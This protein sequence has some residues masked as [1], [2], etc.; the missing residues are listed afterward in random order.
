[1]SNHV[2]FLEQITKTFGQ[3]S[4]RLQ[5]LKGIDLQVSRGECL[6]IVGPSGAGKS[7]LMHIA[8]GLMSPTTG[9]VELQGKALPELCD[10]ELSQVRNRYGGFIV[11]L[12][13]RRREFSAGENVALP[14]LMGGETLGEVRPR[15]H[16]L[17]ERVGLS[18]RAQHRPG[19]LS[20][21]EQQRVAIARAL[22][23]RPA[24]LLA[25]EPTGDL[26]AVT[27]EGIHDLLLSLTRE[28]GQTLVLVTHN[29]ELS[30]LADRIITLRDGKI[31]V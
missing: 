29:P 10:L 22:I 9:R 19:E 26:D 23:N 18:E 11:Q 5:V 4:K 14:A 1:M 27:A 21:G 12:H 3:N 13:Q 24:L 15:A 30:R 16:A 20:G 31:V 7:T 17:L 6:A 28:Q 25:D 2:L 8:C